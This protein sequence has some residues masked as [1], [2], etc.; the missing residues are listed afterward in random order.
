MRE[1]GPALLRGPARRRKARTW[2]MQL[3]A[4]SWVRT[5]KAGIDD[6]LDGLAADQVEHH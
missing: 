6:Q 5:F 1:K 3:S 4:F 2:P